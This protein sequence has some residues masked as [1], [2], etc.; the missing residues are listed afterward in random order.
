VK[1]GVD[2]WLKNGGEQMRGDLEAASKEA[3][4]S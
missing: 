3:G 1:A 4:R 2:T